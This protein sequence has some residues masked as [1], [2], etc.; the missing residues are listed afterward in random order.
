MET[1]KYAQINKTDHRTLG[2]NKEKKEDLSRLHLESKLQ[3]T[4]PRLYD[5]TLQFEGVNGFVQFSL[6]HVCKL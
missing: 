3:A 5:I 4:D 2:N 1:V 6:S